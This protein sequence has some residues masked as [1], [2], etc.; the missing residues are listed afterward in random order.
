MGKSVIIVGGGASGLM[1]A[2]AAARAG[3]AV[4]VLEGSEKCGKKLLLTGNGRCNLTNTD[5][6]LPTRYYG[7]GAQLAEAVIR[8]F[9]VE[10]TL[11]F[12][13]ELGLLVQEKNGYVYP[14][15]AQSSSVLE[16]LLAEL[17]RLGVKVKCKEKVCACERAGG[18]W[19]VRT[20]GWQYT[21]DALILA[22]GSKAAPATGSDGSGYAL[23]RALGHRIIAL[24]PALVPVVCTGNLFAPLAGVRCRAA[25]SLYEDCNEGQIPAVVSGKIKPQ[26]GSKRLLKRETGELQWTKYGVS[27]I[28]VFQLSRFVSAAAQPERLHLIIDLLPD[29]EAE[30]LTELL[31]TRAAQLLKER[32]AVLLSGCL[33]EKLIA[34]VQREAG[35]SAGVSCASLT[36]DDICRLVCAAKQLR[37]GV[38]GTK[39]FDVCQ[40]CSGGVDG[41]QVSSDGLR[42]KK[43]EELYFA[44]ELLDVD[45]PCGGY[46]LQWAWSAGYA[47]GTAAGQTEGKEEEH[48]TENQ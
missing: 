48:G 22:C 24:R 4:T 44:G 2:I 47:A 35:I 9:D 36:D 23:A 42:S 25:V 46:N 38:R 41:A 1:A 31:K 26:D 20:Q 40:V 18:V 7:S 15:T 17:R 10:K 32:T 34:A 5:P 37:L 30:A 33:H 29:F 3:A 28:V 6:Q 39:S 8:R 13:E 19:Q 45:G 27:G 43:Q 12:F 14:Y 11:A 16:V 21:A